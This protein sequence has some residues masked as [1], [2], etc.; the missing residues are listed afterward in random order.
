MEDAESGAYDFVKRTKKK[1][2]V[3]QLRQVYV[4]KGCVFHKYICFTHFYIQGHTGLI[5][6]MEGFGE[7]GEGD[8]RREIME[9]IHNKNSI[10]EIPFML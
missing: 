2:C 9:I 8:S 10:Y 7:A 6:T 1:T 4:H 3:C 5:W